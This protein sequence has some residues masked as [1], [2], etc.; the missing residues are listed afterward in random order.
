VT[1]PPSPEDGGRAPAPGDGAS[2]APEHGGRPQSHRAGDPASVTVRRL[3]PPLGAV[4][5]VVLVIVSLLFLNGR[6]SSPGA[7]PAIEQPPTTSPTPASSSPSPPAPAVTPTPAPVTP[8]PSV[9]PTAP[10]P[11]VS[12]PPATTAPVVAKVPVTVL[13]NSRRNGLGH[14]VAAELEAKGWPIAKVGNYR[15][16]IAKTTVYYRPGQLPQARELA[17]EFPQIRRLAPRFAGLPGQGLT[18]VVTR[19][20]P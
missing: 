14:E 7:G 19:D 4:G 18:V 3:L 15:G 9:S 11:P 10:A 1:S 17:R 5:A 2:A 12:E 13:N 6:S 20:W 16:R 8:T